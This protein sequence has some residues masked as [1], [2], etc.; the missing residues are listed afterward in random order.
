MIKKL[1]TMASSNYRLQEIIW[2]EDASPSHTT[3][4]IAT[5]ILQGKYN[6]EGFLTITCKMPCF[7]TLLNLQLCLNETFLY[8]SQTFAFPYLPLGKV[9]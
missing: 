2:Q 6:P 4:S 8:V 5:K 7:G 3:D 1:I 9:H